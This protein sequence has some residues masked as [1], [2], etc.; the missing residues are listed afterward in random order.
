MFLCATA[1]ETSCRV[2]KKGKPLYEDGR[3]GAWSGCLLRV[4]TPEYLI[5]LTTLLNLS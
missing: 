4:A 2:D 1:I 3:G 5:P